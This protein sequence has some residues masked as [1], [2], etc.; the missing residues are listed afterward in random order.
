MEANRNCLSYWFPKLVAAGVPVPRTEIVRTDLPLM[1]MLDGPGIPENGYLDAAEF[2]ELSKRHDAFI[3]ELTAAAEKI[4]GGAPVFLRSGQ[5]SGKHDWSNCCG[6]KDLSKI[7]EHVW[8]IV[9]F[10]AIVDFMGLAVDVWCVR[11]MLPTTPLTTLPRYGGM[12][13]VRELRAFVKDGKILCAHPYWPEDSI[14]AGLKRTEAS[15]H[16]V[17]EEAH[18]LYLNSQVPLDQTGAV[19]GLASRVAAAFAD[20]GAWSVDLLETKIGWY[21]TDMAEAHR[22]FHWPECPNVKPTPAPSPV[23]A[24]G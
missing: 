13:L 12:P 10:S 14:Y 6:V 23:E 9:N 18:Q 24:E 17:L 7:G 21:V 11:E 4:G 2:A 20:D 19:H 8:G 22:S 16:D 1:R 15:R 3:G 5:T